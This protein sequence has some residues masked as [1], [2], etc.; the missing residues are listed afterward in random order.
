M[1]FLD[2]LEAWRHVPKAA[3]LGSRMA[4]LPVVAESLPGT[5]S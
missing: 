4:R 2:R 1:W 5:Y 3:M